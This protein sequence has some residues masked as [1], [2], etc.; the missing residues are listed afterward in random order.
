[1]KVLVLWKATKLCYQRV[2]S[3]V[4]SS[5]QYWSD[6]LLEYTRDMIS[7][8]EWDPGLLLVAIF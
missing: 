6:M 3:A 2:D 8:P 5:V 7:T 1:M 4:I